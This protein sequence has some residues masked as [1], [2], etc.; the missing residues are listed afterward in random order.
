[1][2]MILIIF[3]TLLA[4]GIGGLLIWR[5]TMMLGLAILGGV[6]NVW[7]M[8]RPHRAAKT[9]AVAPKPAKRTVTAPVSAPPQPYSELLDRIRGA[10]WALHAAKSAFPWLIAVSSGVRVAL[11]PRPVGEQVTADDIAEAMAAKAA[12]GAQFAAIICEHRPSEGIAIL[13]KENRIHIVN[14]ARLEAYLALALSFKP[15]QPVAA[16]AL[17]RVIA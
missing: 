10:G 12:D 17:Q 14:L 13:A 11:R 4:L 2:R 9:E 3:G 7:R 6:I 5:P 15:A 16:P 8:H 1:M